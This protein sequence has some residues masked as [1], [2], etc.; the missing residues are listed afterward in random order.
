MESPHA[1]QVFVNPYGYTRPILTVREARGLVL[2]GAPSTDFTW[3]EGYAWTVAGC[4]G[5]GQH[6]GWR[7]DTTEARRPGCFVG[8]LLEAI[9]LPD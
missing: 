9:L 6:V 2:Y 1:V 3:F 4:A 8:F 7:Y 5:C